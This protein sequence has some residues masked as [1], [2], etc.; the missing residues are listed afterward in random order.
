MG[1]VEWS[2]QEMHCTGVYREKLIESCCD[3][4]IAEWVLDRTLKVFVPPGLPDPGSC[5]LV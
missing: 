4:H 2:G 3:A 1:V 5:D